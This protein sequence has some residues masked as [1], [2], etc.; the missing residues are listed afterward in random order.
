M[1]IPAATRR[2][3]CH[4]RA[5]DTDRK[6]VPELVGKPILRTGRHRCHHHSKHAA[7]TEQGAS[8]QYF[9]VGPGAKPRLTH[10][11]RPHATSGPAIHSTN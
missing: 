5:F 7:G 2:Y 8:V 3:P 1:K 10:C 4:H 9:L 11:Q 6:V